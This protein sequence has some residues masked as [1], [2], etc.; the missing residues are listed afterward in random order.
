MAAIR[1]APGILANAGVLEGINATCYP[2]EPISELLT[3]KGANY[4]DETVVVQGDIITGNGPE[5]S[6]AFGQALATAP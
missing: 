5:A 2:Y 6:T 3:S 1:A 4:V